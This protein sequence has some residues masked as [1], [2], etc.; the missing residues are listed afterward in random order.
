MRTPQRSR[1]IINIF[2]YYMLHGTVLPYY[3]LFLRNKGLDHTTIGILIGVWEVFGILGPIVIGFFADRSGR[4][5]MIMTFCALV[6]AGLL[7]PF[8]STQA[9]PLMILLSAGYGFLFKPIGPMT[10]AYI[11]HRLLD[12]KNEYGQVRFY[13]SLGFI[14]MMIFFWVTG[15]FDGDDPTMYVLGSIT[16]SALYVVTVMI[17]PA[18]EVIHHRKERI[19]VSPASVPITPNTSERPNADSERI[20]NLFWFL[21]G[22]IVLGRFGMSSHFSF[23]SIFLQEQVGFEHVS[24]IWLIGVLAEILP[25]RYGGRI[26]RRIGVFWGIAL[27]LI[28]I[29]TRLIIYSLTLSPLI[30]G[31]SQLLH[32]LTF[33]VFHVACIDFIN[34]RVPKQHKTLAISLYMS[35]GWGMTTF[36]GSAV[37]GFIIERFGYSVLFGS[38]A[39]PP[40]IGLTLLTTYQLT[41]RRTGRSESF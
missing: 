37:G 9:L 17:L 14:T 34:H 27:G 10:D 18:H 11:S 21:L 12:P 4:F 33:G 24:I 3:Q 39:L 26:I 23:F 38:F 20:P 22:V 15:I 28:A 1:L 32:G 8:I 5:R 35:I 25:L 2:F 36:I 19:I 31:A 29:A 16:T 7:V 13:G 40:L 6:S 41:T 30:L